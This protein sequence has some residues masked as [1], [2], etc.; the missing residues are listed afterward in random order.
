[1]RFLLLF[2]M[3]SSKSLWGVRPQK[4]I[5]PVPSIIPKEKKAAIGEERERGKLVEMEN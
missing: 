1:M 3:G 4:Q 5:A 2:R